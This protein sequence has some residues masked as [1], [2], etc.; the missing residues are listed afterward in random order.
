MHQ[1]WLDGP[2]G[3]LTVA[4]FSHSYDPDRGIDVQRHNPR[5]GANGGTVQEQRVQVL[6]PARREAVAGF[7]RLVRNASTATMRECFL[8]SFKQYA[9]WSLVRW[10]VGEVAR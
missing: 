7:S 4:T 1:L 6:P 10:Q 9:A 2:E 3:G 5:F 8:E